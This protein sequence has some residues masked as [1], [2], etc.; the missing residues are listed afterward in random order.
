M[1]KSGVNRMRVMAV[2]GMLVLA[3]ASLPASASHD[4][5][6]IAPLAA[7]IAITALAQ[8]DHYGHYH[9]HGHYRHQY[10]PQHR[11]S[12]SHGGYGYGGPRPKHHRNW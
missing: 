6:F 12:H 2:A 8:H 5:D 9:H 10:R 11:H 4:Q 3:S 7:F 1:I